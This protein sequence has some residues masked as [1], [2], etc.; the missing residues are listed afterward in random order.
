MKKSILLL[1][2]L[3][4]MQ[5]CFQK[6]LTGKEHVRMQQAAGNYDLDKWAKEYRRLNNSK[7]KK[8]PSVTI[9][10]PKRSTLSPWM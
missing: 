1:A 10:K 3:I 7:P 5:S 4:G 9:D 6:A 2:L 8:I